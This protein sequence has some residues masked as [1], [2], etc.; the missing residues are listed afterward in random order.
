MIR[1]QHGRIVELDAIRAVAVISM[2]IGH[3]AN[4]SFTWRVTHFPYVVWDGAQ[5]FMLVSGTVVGIVQQRNLR[6]HGMRWVAGKLAKRA[7]LLYVLQVLLVAFAMFAFFVIDSEWTRQFKPAFAT[8]LGEA[9]RENLYLAVNPI[10]VNFLTSYVVIL[11]LAIPAIWLLARGRWVWMLA[12][13]TALLLA[14]WW[15]PQAFTPPIGPRMDLM[16]N[17]ATWWFLFATGLLAGWFWQ[18]WQ[19]G[20][21]LMSRR[22][23]VVTLALWFAML[24]VAILDAI[25]PA[26][27]AW[28][29]P[30]FDKNQ[31]A[32]GRILSSWVFFIILWWIAIEVHR[33]SWGWRIINPMAVLGSRALDAVVIMTIAAIAI[34]AFLQVRSESR[35]AQLL[36]LVTLAV[37]WAWAYWRNRRDRR[38]ASVTA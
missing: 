3:V 32:P 5:L 28:L 6:R 1:H 15:R 8:S 14:G 18:H 25:A 34:P 31:M 10:Y 26:T 16:F 17:T 29:L 33:R 9:L 11:L 19:V 37:C 12:A 35:W 24:A 30:M 27:V 38:S 7:L 36:A 13:S 20:R 23:T 2:L 22:V 21:W 4:Y